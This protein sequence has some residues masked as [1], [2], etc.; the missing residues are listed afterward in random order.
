MP[1]Y[2]LK[3]IIEQ[4]ILKNQIRSLIA[5][6]FFNNGDIRVVKFLLSIDFDIACRFN[7][8]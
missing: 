6:F 2:Y 8:M 5:I 3:E 7:N 4:S 1:G